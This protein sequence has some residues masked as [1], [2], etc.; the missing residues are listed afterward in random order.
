MANFS[1]LKRN[2]PVR[3]KENNHECP[4]IPRAVALAQKPFISQIADVAILLSPMAVWCHMS[5]I[6]VYSAFA[7]M[8]TSRATTDNVNR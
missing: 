5:R 6:L 4:F 1:S 8:E 2:I 3:P 7:S